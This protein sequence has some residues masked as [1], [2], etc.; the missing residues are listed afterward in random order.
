M[1]NPKVSIIVPCYNVEDYLESS[2]NSIFLQTYQNIEIIAINDGSTD[3]TLD[4]LKHFKKNEQNIEII[5]QNNHGLSASRNIGLDNSHG[6]YV[7]FFDSDDFLERD[8]IEKLVSFSENSRSDIIT[9][10]AKTQILI[11]DQDISSER[12]IVHDKLLDNHLYT[13]DAFLS[14]DRWN[15]SPVWIYFFKRSFL[16]SNNI[17]FCV[18]ILH[19]DSLFYVQIL[20]NP[21]ILIGYINFKFLIYN[22]RPNS[23]SSSNNN[24][25]DRVR[26]FKIIRSK[27]ED[28]L[29]SKSKS[30]DNHYIFEKFLKHRIRK[31]DMFIL[32]YAGN[33]SFTKTI[34]YMTKNKMLNISNIFF[35]VKLLLKKILHRFFTNKI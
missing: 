14:K 24:Y 10:N 5:N 7:Y 20:S 26:S 28:M 22:K 17:R 31:T 21:D 12:D 9:F 30:L 2:L 35:L 16:I 4:I 32:K 33:G 18:G 8:A 29:L 11:K 3:S 25:T 23:I 13:R 1:V 15:H 19:E 34:F 27:L 6:K